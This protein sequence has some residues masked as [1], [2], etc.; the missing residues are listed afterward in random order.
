MNISDCF[1]LGYISKAIGNNGELAF[2]LDVDSPSSYEGI[3]AVFVQ[4]HK[5]DKQLIPFFINSSK[6]QNNGLLRCTIEDLSTLTDAKKLIGKSLYLPIEALPELEE[7]QFYYHEI[8]NYKVVDKEKG[9]I[10]RVADVFETPAAHIL[11]IIFNEK[12]IL[13]PINDQTI[14]RLDR[15]NKTLYIIATDGL[16]DLYLES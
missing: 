15:E 12:E 10:G 6:L 4:M 9:E 14:D 13:V 8:I 5:K 1:Y 3:D 2:K 7:D 11:S 16:I